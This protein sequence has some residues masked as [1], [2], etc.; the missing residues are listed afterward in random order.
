MKDP[1]LAFARCRSIAPRSPHLDAFRDVGDPLADEAFAEIRS[2]RLQDLRA[3]AARTDGAA[4]AL[5]EHVETVPE[6]VDFDCMQPSADFAFRN[7]VGGG[8]ALL[9]GSLV[10][11]FAGAKGAKVLVRSGQLQT[12]TRR[13]LFETAHFVTTIAACAGP[14]PG[15]EA[16][17]QTVRV[18]LL[19][20]G[21]RADIL[22]GDW[23][24]AW[25]HPVNQE[26]NAGTLFMFGRVYRRA[27]KRIGVR[28]SSAESDG[29]HHIWRYTGYLLGVDP[30]LLTR[31]RHEE[32]E[33]YATI[34]AR[35]CHPDSDSVA[36]THALL[37]ATAGQSPFF[38]PR[39]ALHA[40][41]RR[42]IGDE[43]GDALQLDRSRRWQ[44]AIATA[45]PINLVRVAAH[46]VSGGIVEAAGRQL[47][48]GIV[49]YELGKKPPSFAD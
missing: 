21:V 18:R 14:R 13:R 25:G 24:D 8:L 3:H 36:L 45:N 16:W 48:S 5:L 31:N 11:S 6:W 37:D 26:D 15:T 44:A 9:C 34:S 28:M 10:E 42:M 49:R 46:S 33:L 40:L 19:H 17:D 20:A 41:S 27:L 29:G 47:A 39:G 38:I 23:N 30:E 43:L 2:I 1:D 12:D 22:R 4:R 32:A 35:Q 7:V